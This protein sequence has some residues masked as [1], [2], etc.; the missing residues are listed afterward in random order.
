LTLFGAHTI[1][2]PISQLL[3][4]IFRNRDG[5]K[6]VNKWV[7]ELSEHVVDFEKHSTIMFQILADFMAE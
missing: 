3:D 7:M 5:S 2:I 6:R 4:D 1:R